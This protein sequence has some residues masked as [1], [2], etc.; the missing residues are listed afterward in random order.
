MTKR[1]DTQDRGTGPN[2]LD[3]TFGPHSRRSEQLRRE[4]HGGILEIADSVFTHLTLSS[5]STLARIAER[6]PDTLRY[7][8]K[9][10]TLLVSA[11]GDSGDWTSSGYLEVCCQL[12]YPGEDGKIKTSGKESFFRSQGGSQGLEQAFE[13]FLRLIADGVLD[14]DGG[15]Q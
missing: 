8:P 10:S 4:T 14:S 15:V 12:K 13:G 1:I 6:Y 3:T 7:F 11:S 5:V 9:G 2:P